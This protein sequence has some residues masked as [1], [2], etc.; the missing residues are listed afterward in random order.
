MLW[1]TA[2]LTTQL[3]PWLSDTNLSCLDCLQNHFLPLITDQLVSTP[4]EVLWLEADVQSYPTC[5]NRLILKAKEKVLHST[6]NHPKHIALD[7]N[8]PQ[9]FQNRSSFR[10]KAEELST[11]LSPD[12][13]H[14]QNIIQF[15]SPPWQQSSSHKGL[16]VTTVYGITGR[17]NDSNQ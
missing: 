14:R 11:L 4:L 16:I 15:P 1:S 13:Q 6:V 9:R 8:I 17:A 3:L 12:L 7:V 2:S 10:Q 5:D